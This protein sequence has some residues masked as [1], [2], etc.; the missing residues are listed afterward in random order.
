MIPEM[1]KRPAVET[2]RSIKTLNTQSIAEPT[3]K[4]ALYV[5]GAFVALVETPAGKY[6]RRV[7]LTLAAAEKAVQRAHDAGHSATVVLC[8]LTP[9]GGDR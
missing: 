2:G 7:F 5:S 1:R 3:D 6:R 9:V 8:Q 4:A